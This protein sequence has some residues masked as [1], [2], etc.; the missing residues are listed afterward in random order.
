M[1]CWTQGRSGEITWQ[2]GNDS[3]LAVITLIRFLTTALQVHPTRQEW[4]RTKRTWLH[5][6]EGV[7]DFVA[8]FPSLSLHPCGI[9][10]QALEDSVVASLCSG[11]D[12]FFNGRSIPGSSNKKCTTNV[13]KTN[14]VPVSGTRHVNAVQAFWKIYSLHKQS[15]QRTA[16][17]LK[18]RVRRCTDVTWVRK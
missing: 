8:N 18:T 3:G 2:D 5:F 10:S 17:N 15:F 9:S 4:H 12:G 7:S 16:E 13:A 14:D 1:L 6:L 11:Q